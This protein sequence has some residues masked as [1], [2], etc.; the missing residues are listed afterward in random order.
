MGKKNISFATT[1]TPLPQKGKYPIKP[2]EPA[3]YKLNP[4]FSFR[5]YHKNHRDLTFQKLKG[6]KEFIDFFDRMEQLSQYDWKEIFV[7]KKDYYHAH[8]VHWC[9]TA[10]KKGF[11]H[12]PHPFAEFPAFQFEIF[13]ECRIFGFFNSTNVFKIVWIDREHIVYPKKK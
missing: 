7:H 9:N 12:L 1:Q 4:I 8:E 5:F 10:Y 11:S 6:R 2:T 3:Y 13:K